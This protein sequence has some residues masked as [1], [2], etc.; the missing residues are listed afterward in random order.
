VLLDILRADHL[1]GAEVSPQDALAIQLRAIRRLWVSVVDVF[2]REWVASVADDLLAGVLSRRADLASTSLLDAWTRLCS[3][4]VAHGSIG[5]KWLLKME[6]G[7]GDMAVRELLWTIVAK[8]W[9]G[10]DAP[11]WT[12]AVDL[13]VAGTRSVSLFSS[14]FSS[15]LTYLLQAHQTVEG[16]Y[17][18]L[19]VSSPHCSREGTEDIYGHL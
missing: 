4:L 15:S 2:S 19:A 9:A 7:A 12:D 14:P 3:D 6:A 8:A 13:L 11:V 17:L 10:K 5:L 16:E 18:S 1:V